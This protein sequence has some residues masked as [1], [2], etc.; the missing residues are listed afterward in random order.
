MTRRSHALARLAAAVRCN[1]ALAAGCAL[2]ACATQTYERP[3]T[4]ETPALFRSDAPLAG[5]T[6][7]ASLPWQALFSD[8]TLRALI[9]EGLQQNLDLKIASSRIDAARAN[10][11]QSGAALLPTLQ[12]D[13]QYSVIRQVVGTGSPSRV[14]R[15]ELSASASWELDLW[16]KLRSARRATEAQ[17]QA[18]WAYKRA[19]HTQLIAE[20]ATAYYTLLAYD[21]QLAI[22]EEALAVRIKDVEAVKA[23]KEAAVVTGADVVQSE[24]SRYAA[25][26]AI[27][28]IKRN[29]R[30]VE[31]ALCLLL[32]R[33][34]RAI[35]RTTLEQQIP[36]G[37]LALG[38]PA[39]L[40]ANRPDVQQAELEFR[41]AFELTNVARTYFYPALTLSGSAGFA[42]SDLGELFSP[43][44]FIAS[45]LAGLT[46]PILDRGLNKQRLEL[47]RAQQREALFA[48][49]GTLLRA[50]QEVSDA[51]YSHQMAAEKTEARQHQLEALGKSVEFTK[52]LLRYT[53]NTNYVDVLT[54][55]QSLL[56]AQIDGVNDRLQQLQ[57]IVTLYRALGGGWR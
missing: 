54:S 56:T 40:L 36:L 50:G 33:P 5:D 23:L 31:N 53:S 10:L 8:G 25:E 48:F 21:R 11:S 38:I 14:T 37:Q 22:T 17:W 6:S 35:Q 26:V 13:A 32:A 52:D 1:L 39:Q 30:E 45:L 49:Q 34:S 20:I 41:S 16:G 47:A 42:S 19:V 44:S 55:E 12:A 29:I 57:A 9:Q 15:A 4:I 7:I 3:P 2:A 18:S 43:A 24:A 28:D 51:L 27:P 46:Q